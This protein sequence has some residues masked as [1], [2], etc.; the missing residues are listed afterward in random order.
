MVETFLILNRI[1]SN[2]K[3]IYPILD[4]PKYIF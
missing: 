2:I 4:D 1:I 3:V